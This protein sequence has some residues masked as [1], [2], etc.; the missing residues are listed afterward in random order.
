MNNQGRIGGKEEGISITFQDTDGKLE[1]G[2]NVQRSVV[3]F[4]AELLLVMTGSRGGWKQIRADVLKSDQ[5]QKTPNPVNQNVLL[6]FGSFQV[7][8]CVAAPVDLE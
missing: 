1:D 5:D 3:V 6:G 8:H 2:R 4:K 7:G